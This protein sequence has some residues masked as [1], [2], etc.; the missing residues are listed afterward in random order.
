M[1]LQRYRIYNCA[2]IA[3]DNGGYCLSEDVAKIERNIPPKE[4]VDKGDVRGMSDSEREILSKIIELQYLV[5]ET[6]KEANSSE[7]G[8]LMP[9]ISDIQ[10]IRYI[11]TK[12]DANV[13]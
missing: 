12:E 1:T 7:L 9:L 4:I 6:I 8:R 10:L 3:E 11:F 5:S 2:D 13:I